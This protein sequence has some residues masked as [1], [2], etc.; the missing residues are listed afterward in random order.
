MSNQ[1]PVINTDLFRSIVLLLLAGLSATTVALANRNVYTKED[2]DQRMQALEQRSVDLHHLEDERHEQL[3]RQ[4]HALRQDVQWIMR[5][6]GEYNAS[7]RP[8]SSS[9]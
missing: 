3:L 2:V 7:A 5:N 8:D 4:M 9:P 1:I 6:M